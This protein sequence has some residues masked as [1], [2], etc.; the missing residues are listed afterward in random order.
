[1][2]GHRCFT[3]SFD[4]DIIWTVCTLRMPVNMLPFPLQA[5]PSTGK[6]A[7]RE[8]DQSLISVGSENEVH[9]LWIIVSR[10]RESAGDIKSHSSVCLSVRLSVTK[11]LTL[12][13]T[14]ALLQVEL[15]YLA[16]VFIVTLPFWWYHV[17][18]LTM[19]FDLLQG[20]ICCR[21]GDHNSLN[22]LVCSITKYINVSM[23]YILNLL[24]SFAILIWNLE[25]LPW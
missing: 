7:S 10:F 21:A 22:L 18:T 24:V 13:I 14:F 11:T 5:L 12:A 23:Q 17:L 6:S 4:E 19:T 3:N 2:Q 20:Q 16:C 1:M 8:S 9:I 25:I 15:W